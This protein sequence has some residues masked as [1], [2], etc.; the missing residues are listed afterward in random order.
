MELPAHLNA[1]FVRTN[2]SS[3]GSDICP[4]FGSDELVARPVPRT[5]VK[6][7]SP[8]SASLSVRFC[9]ISARPARE[10]AR[11]PQLQSSELVTLGKAEHTVRTHDPLLAL[12]LALLLLRLCALRPACFLQSIRL[13]TPAQQTT[14]SGRLAAHA[15]SLSCSRSFCEA[16]K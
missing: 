1:A 11:E 10:R 2:V 12:L 13:G 6:G 3:C 15:A 16:A 7:A 8:S 4:T 9:C 5:R 14:K